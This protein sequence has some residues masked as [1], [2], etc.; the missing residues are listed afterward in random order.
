MELNQPGG[1]A[2]KFAAIEDIEV[3]SVG[4][5]EVGED[6]KKKKIGQKVGCKLTKNK[7]APPYRTTEFSL[8]YEQGIDRLEEAV[9][10]GSMLNIIDVKGSW[11]QFLDKASGEIVIDKVQGKEKFK[12]SMI[13]VPEKYLK[14]LNSINLIIRE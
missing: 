12:Q 3:Y 5:I 11:Y 7:C 2:L 1:R 4:S 9:T 6:G 14:L 10:I 13:D 8:Y